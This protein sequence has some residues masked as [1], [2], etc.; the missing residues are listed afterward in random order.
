MHLFNSLLRSSKKQ[1]MSKCPVMK[2]QNFMVKASQ[3]QMQ[4][5]L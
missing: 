2:M 5:F 1:Y 4:T 3:K